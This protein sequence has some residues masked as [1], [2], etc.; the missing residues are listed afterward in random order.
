[1]FAARTAPIRDARG[2][3]VPGSIAALE[4]P[5]IGGVKQSVLLRGRS[6]KNPVLL[7]LHGG[8]GTSE[9]G[10]V[11]VHNMPALEQHFT[12]AV[13][14][15]RGAA[16]SFAAIEPRSAIN[17]EQLVSDAHELTLALCERFEQDKIFLVGHSWGSLL[18]ALT[19][20]RYPE[21]YH[22]YVG[23]GQVAD[24]LE[25]ERLS[26]QWTLEQAEK[27]GDTRSVAKLR[28]IG[29][30]PYAEPMRPKVVTQRAILAKYG[31]EVHGNANGGMFILLGCLLRASEYSWRDR[32]N[33][34]RGV[35]ATMDLMWKP[36]LSIN[37]FEQVPELKVPVY[38]LLGRHDQE[39]PS[40]LAARYFEAL[41]APRKALAWFERSAHFMNVEEA[42]AFNRFF[43]ERLLP[44]TLGTG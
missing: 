38:F 1:M 18:G 17:V 30:P 21:R 28:A 3:P 10:M 39:A 13:W 15:Q 2:N 5:T 44:E 36:I 29:P 42:D 20:S 7:F 4:M 8:P 41:R 35:F 27:A 33:L 9:L 25:G 43:V 12:V 40:V 14:D 24:M 31:G 26:Y 16:K 6:V 19:A 11:R 22:A 32:I 23:F 37:L 34:F